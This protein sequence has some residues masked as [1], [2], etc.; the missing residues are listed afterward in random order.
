MMNN[1]VN[2]E[3]NQ[4]TALRSILD[5]T[6]DRYDEL[7]DTTDSLDILIKLVRE[8]SVQ[9]DE[10]AGTGELEKADELVKALAYLTARL[11]L[12]RESLLRHC[13]FMA[14]AFKG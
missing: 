7:T 4:V 12:E 2:T 13:E 10:A 8:K 14:Q 5:N 3:K 1:T 9:L 6:I 11:D